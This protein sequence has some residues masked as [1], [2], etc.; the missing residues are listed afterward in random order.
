MFYTASKSVYLVFCFIYI[1]LSDHT[2]LTFLRFFFFD[3]VYDLQ[4]F[5]DIKF[6][7][8]VKSEV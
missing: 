8:L 4:V 1:T 3:P 5:S 6:K 2:F 7:I